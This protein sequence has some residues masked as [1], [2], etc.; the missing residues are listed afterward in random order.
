MV[1]GAP[2]RW[3]CRRGRLELDILLQ[4]FLERAEHTLDAAQCE[5][6]GRLL[7]LEDDQLL[8]VLTGQLPAPDAA[9]AALATRIG[10]RD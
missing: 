3:Q 4:R 1:S 9:A 2:L 7:D 8:A 6:F 10:N 5:A